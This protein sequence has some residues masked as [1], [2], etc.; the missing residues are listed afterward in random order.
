MTMPTI[1]HWTNHE[2][3]V[4]FFDFTVR[5]EGD[6]LLIQAVLQLWR[7]RNILEEEAFGLW[8]DALEWRQMGNLLPGWVDPTPC[9]VSDLYPA[10]AD[11][12]KY[13][14][15]FRWRERRAARALV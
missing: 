9:A 5:G 11:E 12:E 10:Q 7:E 8:R 2:C 15:F 1:D 4:V 14:D 3:R 13:W 6:S